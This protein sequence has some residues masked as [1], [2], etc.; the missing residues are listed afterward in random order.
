MGS[1]GIVKQ[2]TTVL[3]ERCSTA[4]IDISLESERQ[5]SE[6]ERPKN[7]RSGHSKKTING[8]LNDFFL[9]FA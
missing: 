3:I 1:E 7:R 5:E 6:L 2:V 4:E 9:E 8:E